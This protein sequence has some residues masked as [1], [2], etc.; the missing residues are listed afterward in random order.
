VWSTLRATLEEH[1]LSLRELLERPVQTNEVGRCAA[2]VGGLLLVAR[3]TGL[4][5]RL[6]EVGSSGGLN[7][8][9]DHY[10]YEAPGAAWG[11]AGS[12]VCFAG[13]IVEGTPPFDIQPMIVERRG[14]DL[15][16]VDPCS[17]EGRLTLM[18]YLWA[19]QQVR[20][21]LLEGALEVARRVPAVVD[22]ADAS[23]WLG[24]HLGEA[25]GSV[26]TVVFHSI[27]L[28]YLTSAG[29][30]RLYRVLEEAGRLATA[31]APLAWLRMEPSRAAVEPGSGM[32][33]RLTVWPGGAERVV[34]VA[35][36]HGPPVRWL[37]G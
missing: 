20:L 15:A 14:C 35:S 31:A 1:R 4:P 33:V 36:P 26:A 25:P 3:E 18:S 32:D 5:L 11:D 8:R 23:D 13:A 21:A 2:L 34:A 30:E 10:R 19:D 16:P 9:W 37:A 6:L 27:V 12:P 29:R 28:Q 22:A 7:L 24:L 17:D